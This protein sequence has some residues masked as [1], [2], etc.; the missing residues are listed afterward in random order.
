M[1]YEQP[2]GALTCP[3]TEPVLPRNVNEPAP[4]A[5]DSNRPQDDAPLL[6]AMIAEAN[7]LPWNT[8]PP[9]IVAEL[10]TCRQTFEALVTTLVNFHPSVQSSHRCMRRQHGFT[11][12]FRS[13]TAP[14]SRGI[15]KM[16]V[17]WTCTNRLSCHVII[18]SFQGSGFNRR[19]HF[20]ILFVL[21]LSF[22]RGLK[23]R[24][25]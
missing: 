8:L 14:K 18:L 9:L 6:I 19:Q 11:Y 5:P 13:M 3:D 15:Q 24:W 16:L 4:S 17:T 23:L 1:S 25:R 21:T 10:P 7:T 2:T 12:G 22:H 20:S